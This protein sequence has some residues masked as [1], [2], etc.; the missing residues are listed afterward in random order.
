[1]NNDQLRSLEEHHREQLQK[2]AYYLIALAVTCVGFSI[3]NTASSKL[4]WTHLL[5]GI[6]VLFWSISINKG[7]RL[8][9]ARITVT[10]LNHHYL[11]VEEQKIRQLYSCLTQILVVY[12]QWRC[13]TSAHDSM[14]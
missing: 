1:M 8:L 12:L 13:G 14:L 9:R 3:H 11:K 5:L 6:A 7:L 4:E 2:Y 10:H